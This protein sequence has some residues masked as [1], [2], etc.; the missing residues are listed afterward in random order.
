MDEIERFKQDLLEKENPPEKIEEAVKLLNYY[1]EFLKE[2]DKIFETA[3]ADDF[4]R[5]SRY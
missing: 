2:Q 4:Y 5:F 1:Q 3:S